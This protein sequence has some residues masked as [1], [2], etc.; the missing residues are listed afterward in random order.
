MGTAAPQH[1]SNSESATVAPPVSVD[2][3][4]QTCR[5]EQFLS[6]DAEVTIRTVFSWSAIALRVERSLILDDRTVIQEYGSRLDAYRTCLPQQRQKWRIAGAAE[7][8]SRGRRR[9]CRA[10]CWSRPGGWSADVYT[11]RHVGDN[12]RGVS[13][14][15]TDCSDSNPH[16]ATTQLSTRKCPRFACNSPPAGPCGGGVVV[17]VPR[18]IPISRDPGLQ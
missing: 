11:S 3:V 18:G 1:G 16:R 8:G 13:G 7:G 6:V 2:A 10:M 17:V 5:G 12:L 14:F 9:L 4:R 15:A